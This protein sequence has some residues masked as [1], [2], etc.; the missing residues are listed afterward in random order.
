MIQL[1]DKFFKPY[2]SEEGVDAI[3]S[4]MVDVF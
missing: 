3:V 4:E 1:H 2:I